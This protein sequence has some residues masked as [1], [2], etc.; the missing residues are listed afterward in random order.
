MKISVKQATEMTLLTLSVD[1]GLFRDDRGPVNRD[2]RSR[3]YGVGNTTGSWCNIDG[4]E[5]REVYDGG[6]RRRRNERPVSE[7]Y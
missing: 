5:R 4:L 7:R 6:R 2:G 3:S 1:K